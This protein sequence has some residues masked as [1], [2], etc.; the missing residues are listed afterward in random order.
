MPL[1]ARCILNRLCAA[2]LPMARTTCHRLDKRLSRPRLERL[3]STF[4]L[5]T[6]AFIMKQPLNRGER[7]GAGVIVTGWRA[8]TPVIRHQQRKAAVADGKSP[9]CSRFGIR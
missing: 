2:L 5:L 9:G 8:G 7:V 4:A 6:A 1:E 3:P